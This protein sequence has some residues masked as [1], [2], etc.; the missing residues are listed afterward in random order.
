MK[1]LEEHGLKN[2]EDFFVC[3]GHSSP[4]GL[5]QTLHDKRASLILYDDCDSTLVD[6]TCVNLLKA[7]LDSYD[8][9]II[10]WQSSRA[11]SLDLERSFE[12][13]GQVIFISNMNTGR[14]DEAIKS[15]AFCYD[16][17]LSTD[18]M[19]QYMQQLLPNIM[20]NIDL[21][22]KQEV[23]DYLFKYRNVW[24]NYNLRTL[25]QAIRI[26]AGVSANKDWKK[27]VQILSAGSF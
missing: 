8:K 26:C 20:E 4:L 15:R 22:T 21:T 2:G 27:I 5:Y 23:L 17:H 6:D 25:I 16:L 14:I 9:R 24:K 12:F 18:E 19:H 13:E 7:A 10:S 11:D 3:K 1:T